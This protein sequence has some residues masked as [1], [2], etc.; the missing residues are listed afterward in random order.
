MSGSTLQV[1][2]HPL[3]ILNISE[4]ATRVAIQ[5]NDPNI[6]V[7]GGLLGTQQGREIEILN[8]FEIVLDIQNLQLDHAY[9][10]TRK[11]QF[12]QVFPTFDFL[13]WYSIGDAPSEQ[14]ISIHKQFFEYNE[15]PLFLQLSRSSTTASQSTSN[16]NK[17][18]PVS[19]YESVIELVDNEATVALVKASYEIE[20]GE[21]ERVAVDH[22]SKTSATSGDDS[23]SG[24]IA[25]LSTQRNAIKM[26]HDRIALI[27]QYLTAV[28]A[29]T[30]GV[31]KDQETL[32]QISALVASLQHN[33]LD[34]FKDE[35]MMEYND[36]LLTTYLA[37][38][39]KQLSTANELL[40]KQLLLVPGANN[41]RQRD[42]GGGG[43]GAS[44]RA[45]RG[46]GDFFS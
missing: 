32:R 28:A 10:V 19:I 3:P 43:G 16:N 4:H 41:D 34:E 6:R 46:K 27:V 12:R 44:G 38:I 13:G 9:F 22:V 11:E 7:I 45:R 23:Q 14:D 39:T 42:G 33:V 40:D 37:T 30:P 25:N 2:L 5:Q 31:A 24:L 1:S 8:S 35:F 18:L 29:D 17:D 26:L 20:T 15:T 21:A 36:V